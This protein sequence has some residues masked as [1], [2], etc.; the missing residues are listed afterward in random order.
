MPNVITARLAPV[1]G[2]IPADIHARA[3]ALG[4]IAETYAE[5]RAGHGVTGRVAWHV[6]FVAEPRPGHTEVVRMRCGTASTEAHALVEL[7]DALA[8][9]EPYAERIAAMRA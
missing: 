8:E 3:A 9:L 4:M 5:T 1:I 2:R 6:A 7:R